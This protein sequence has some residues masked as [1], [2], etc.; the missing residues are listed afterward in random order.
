MNYLG[1]RLTRNTRIYIFCYHV[2]TRLV[3]MDTRANNFN[4]SSLLKMCFF[5]NGSSFYS[6]NSVSLC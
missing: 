2:N 3:D 1:K 5:L 4:L 6:N